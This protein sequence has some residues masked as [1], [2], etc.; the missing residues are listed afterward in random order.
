MP[1]DADLVS[2]AVAGDQLAFAALYRQLQPGLLR[3]LRVV[4]P[5]A[6]EDV[7]SETWL[8]VARD[9]RGFEGDA[10][11][12]RAW[13]FTIGRHRA[14]DWVRRESRR[15]STPMAELPDVPGEDRTAAD[16]LES[17]DTVAALALIAQLPPDQAEA[18]VLRVV[19]GLDV[20]TV[21]R[22]L[23]K[24][25]GAVRTNTLR[26]LRRLKALLPSHGPSVGSGR[27]V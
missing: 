10:K 4:V 7:A 23:G 6:A 19:A 20:A 13:V 16:V 21:A 3:Y 12:F 22:I 15:P 27:G 5:G 24:R 11:G 14:L 25:P 8:E 1:A 26:G 17:L 18:I 2:A 9:I